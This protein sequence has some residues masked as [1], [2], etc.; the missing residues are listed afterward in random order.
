M[1]GSLSRNKGK[2]GE[3]EV[4][5]LLRS[6]G[7]DAR[8][9][10]QFCGL[11]QTADLTTSLDGVHCEVKRYARIGAVRFM[12]QAKRDAGDGIPMV[13][14]IP[15]DKLVDFSRKIVATTETSSSTSGSS[16]TSSDGGSRQTDSSGKPTPTN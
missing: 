11:E 6:Q 5:D 12:E 2:R 14:M 15:L 1:S 16:S 3:R 9:S 7:I 4:A 8:R 13:A 10:Q